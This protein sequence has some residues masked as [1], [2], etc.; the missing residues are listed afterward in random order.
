MR[1]RLQRLI[2]FRSC[3]A[4]SAFS[5]ACFPTDCLLYSSAVSRISIRAVFCV[6]L[7]HCSALFLEYFLRLVYK[8]F[9]ALL[10]I[11]LDQFY[12]V[13]RALFCT[14]L[15]QCSADLLSCNYIKDSIYV[16]HY[17]PSLPSLNYLYI[18]VKMLYGS[19]FWLY[20][21]G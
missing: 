7:Q 1:K 20:F 11:W 18:Y 15:E 19:I 21:W 16:S 9:G 17:I 5:G 3:A 8:F 2:F 14:F 6:L 10:C 12:C 13:Y 4:L